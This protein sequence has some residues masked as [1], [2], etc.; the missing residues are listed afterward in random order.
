MYYHTNVPATSW[1]LCEQQ[2]RILS[3]LSKAVTRRAKFQIQICITSPIL[4]IVIQS[5]D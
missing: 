2:R 4:Q 5:H 1:H 3:H